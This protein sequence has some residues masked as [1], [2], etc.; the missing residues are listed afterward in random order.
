MLHSSRRRRPAQKKIEEGERKRATKF[1]TGSATMEKVERISRP[2][3]KPTVAKYQ[4]LR[5]IL[6]EEFNK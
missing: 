2:C 3:R 4:T 6:R 1:E 5:D